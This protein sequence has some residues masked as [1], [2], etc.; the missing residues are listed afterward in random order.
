MGSISFLPA[1]CQIITTPDVGISDDARETS[2]RVQRVQL[3]PAQGGFFKPPSPLLGEIFYTRSEK[4]CAV[5]LT[6]TAGVGTGASSATPGLHSR[7]PS[8]RNSTR[9]G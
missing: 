4:R 2:A 7:R 8:E 6:E 1:H 3:P 9:A 5:W